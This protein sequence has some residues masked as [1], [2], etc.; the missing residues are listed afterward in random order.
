MQNESV[1]VQ[2]GFTK[3]YTGKPP[4]DIGKQQAP[5]IAAADRVRSPL[6]DC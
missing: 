2:A 4:W 3:K 6:L 5:F 1:S